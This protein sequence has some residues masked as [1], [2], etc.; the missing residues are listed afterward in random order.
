MEKFDRILLAIIIFFVSVFSLVGVSILL[1]QNQTLQNSLEEKTAILQAQEDY[2]RDLNIF[3]T[4]KR[5]GA[6]IT[7]GAVFDTT[8]SALRSNGHVVWTDE[9]DVNNVRELILIQIS[10]EQLEQLQGGQ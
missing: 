8:E 4:G 7:A 9:R 10:R 3:E 6:N 2:L 1:N 5:V